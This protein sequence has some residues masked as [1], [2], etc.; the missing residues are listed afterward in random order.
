MLRYFTEI[1]ETTEAVKCRRCGEYG[2][3]QRSCTEKARVLCVHCLGKHYS[4]ECTQITCMKCNQPGHMIRVFSKLFRI[5]S[6]RL[7]NVINAT[8]LVID[9]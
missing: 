8:N 4:R 9:K 2:H 5:V 6:H 3:Y 1:D 7:R